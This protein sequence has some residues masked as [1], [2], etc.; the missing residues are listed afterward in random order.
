MKRSN[1][2]LLFLLP[3][4]FMGIIFPAFYCTFISESGFSGINGYMI[5]TVMAVLL[6]VG[7][8]IM[9]L[10][11]ERKRRGIILA[12]LITFLFNLFF[13]PVSGKDS[14]VRVLVRMTSILVAGK[15]N[16][17]YDE[18]LGFRSWE[19]KL[20]SIKK[21]N[22]T[23]FPHKSFVFRVSQTEKSGTVISIDKTNELENTVIYFKDG[24]PCSDDKQLNLN[25]KN[26]GF[27]YF[28]AEGKKATLHFKGENIDE[29]LMKTDG[30]NT[31]DNHYS[32]ELADNITAY[33]YP[34]D[35][36]TYYPQF[37]NQYWLYR[38]FYKLC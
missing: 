2:I 11:M 16:V 18:A 34:Y 17:S 35:A 9:L 25:V 26:D 7:L 6:P 15:K 3:F 8:G 33:L 30:W 20:A 1:K 24:K 12:V 32:K 31:E 19:D 37:L 27:D 10:R 4:I 38:L 14:P 22:E 13:L 28:P 29:A 21:Y 5:F 36:N 23:I